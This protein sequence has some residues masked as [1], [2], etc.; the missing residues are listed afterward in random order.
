[1]LSETKRQTQDFVGEAKERVT[2]EVREQ[3]GRAAG[4][5]R[6]WADDL[7]RMADSTDDDSPARS[8]VSQLADQGRRVADQLKDEGPDGLVNDVRAFARR[9]PGT[10]LLSSAL[11]GFAV[12]R[13]TRAVSAAPSTTDSTPAPRGGMSTQGEFGG[14]AEPAPAPAPAP[15]TMPP[16]PRPEVGGVGNG[17]GGRQ[18]P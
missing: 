16:A 1:M 6:K 4:T 17:L 7:S 10:F 18:V 9:K 12:G 15:A 5:L 11:A 8:L 3:T 13:I 2:E 14:V